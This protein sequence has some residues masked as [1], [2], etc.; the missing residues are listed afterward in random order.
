MKQQ[1]DIGLSLNKG[2]ALGALLSIEISLVVPGCELFAQSASASPANYNAKLQTDC[3]KQLL[4]MS[5]LPTDMTLLGPVLNCN[6]VELDSSERAFD[7][8]CFLHFR[9][10]REEYRPSLQR[11]ARDSCTPPK[12]YLLRRSDTVSEAMLTVAPN[13]TKNSSCR[14][15]PGIRHSKKRSSIPCAFRSLR[16]VDGVALA[17]SKDEL[18]NCAFTARKLSQKPR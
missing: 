1:A 4:G 8:V 17:H 11:L 18:M 5:E 9:H 14:H 3:L 6:S 13:P 7:Y 15:S 2:R 10:L 16:R 12:R